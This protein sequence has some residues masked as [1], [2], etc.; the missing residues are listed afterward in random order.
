MTLKISKS[1]PR[2]ALFVLHLEGKINADTVQTFDRA[3]QDAL[4]QGARYVVLDFTKLSFIASC[5]FRSIVR[6][7]R[8]LQS[9]AGD[10]VAFGM[11]EQ[12]ESVFVMVGFVPPFFK[13]YNTLDDAINDLLEG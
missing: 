5:G 11:Q 3:F 6:T 9:P 4:V 1:N 7:K 2:P 8:N 12:V 10:V 13:T